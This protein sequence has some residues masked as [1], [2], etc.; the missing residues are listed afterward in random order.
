MLNTPIHDIPLVFL[1][2]ETTGLFPYRGDRVCELAL[3]RVRGDTVEASFETLIDPQRAVSEQSFRVNGIGPAAL[4]GAPLFAEVA[5][6]LAQLCAGAALVAHNA[7]FDVEFLRVELA[8]AGLPA[9]SM[10]VIDTLALAR[11]VYPKRA[12]HSLSALAQALGG[13]PPAHRAMG[14]VRALRAVFADL[15][16][17]L[18]EQGVGTLGGLLHYARGFNLGEPAPA[19][20]PL[21]AAALRDDQLLRVVYRSRALPEPT[22][23]IIRPI[24]IVRQRNVLFLRAYCHLR[25][26]L[27]VFAVDKLLDVQVVE[28]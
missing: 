2:T 17:R 14:D 16:A 13:A 23:R 21:I 27:R 18:K 4:A 7:P 8:L 12:S 19:A 20:P 15:A 11:R 26:D 24:E 10:P 9:L 22:E 28:R 1:D 6:Q 25:Q 5:D 3:L